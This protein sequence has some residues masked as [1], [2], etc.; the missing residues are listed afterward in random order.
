MSSGYNKRLEESQRA[1]AQYLAEP[2]HCVKVNGQWYIPLTALQAAPNPLKPSQLLTEDTA[3]KNAYNNGFIK[4]KTPENIRLDSEE[5]IKAI[6]ANAPIIV[7]C[8][9]QK[10]SEPKPKAER[11]V[12]L[13]ALSKK[14]LNGYTA[15]PNEQGGYDYHLDKVSLTENEIKTAVK[16]GWIEQDSNPSQPCR[17]LSIP[18]IHEDV[19]NALSAQLTSTRSY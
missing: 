1:L 15:S 5:V 10:P 12:P 3:I 19:K 17:I 7:K 18:K 4:S 2:E 14:I 9:N 8:A 11:V 13:A 16:N 6:A